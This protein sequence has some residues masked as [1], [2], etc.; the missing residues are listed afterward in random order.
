MT[1]LAHSRRTPRTAAGLAAGAS[2]FACIGCA[3]LPRPPAE[4][5]LYVDLR[6]MVESSE[7]GGWTV[8]RLRLQANAEPA[9]RSVCQVDEA[10]R[11]ALDAWL[12]EQLEL[13]GGPAERRYRENGQRLDGVGESLSLERT[14]ALL[15]YARGLAAADCPF[16]LA[17]VANFSGMQGDVG[18]WVLLAE[19][20]AFATVTFPSAVPALGGG[21]RLFVGHGVGSQLTLALG[22]DVAASG[23]F[24]PSN[25]AG[26]GIDAYL[27]LA[28]PVLLRISRFSRMV[29]LEVAPVMRLAHGQTAWPPGGRV[30]LGAGF[31]SVRTSPLMSYFVFYGGYEVHLGGDGRRPDHTA[32]LGTRIAFDWAP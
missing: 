11:R 29:D 22:A 1:P 8:D 12:A 27:T 17:P 5:A 10:T 9:L 24:I 14:R 16:W 20:Q 7:D 31:A 3:T 19:T 6:K 23:T 28:S 4:R 13:A 32:Q 30:L 21:G 18:R 25:G 2:L 26:Q 15:Q